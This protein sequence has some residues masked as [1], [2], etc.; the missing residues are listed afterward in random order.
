MNTYASRRLQHAK[1]KWLRQKISDGST[2]Q[3]VRELLRKS[4][5]HTVCQEARCPNMGEC[6]SSGTATFLILGERCTRNCRFCAIAHGPI[7]PPDPEE[8]RRVAEAVRRMG[9]CFTVITSVTR[10]DLPDGGAGHF[11][12]AIHEIRDRVPRTLVE[13][14]VP[15]FGGSDSALETIVK[16]RPDVLNHNIETV[17]GLYS[18][19]R[20]GADYSRSLH[21]LKRVRELSPDMPTKSGL[22]LGLGERPD[23]VEK[24][25]ENLLEVGC[26]ILT[27]GQYLQP[28]KNHLPVKRYVPPEEFDKWKEIALGMGFG[29]VASGPFVRSSYHAGELYGALGEIPP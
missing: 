7:G 1:P 11:A 22:M 4:H 18:Q 17:S 25:F 21:L 16:A 19:V 9:L 20:P 2:Y 10:D 24:V 27:L 12:Q 23:E 29:A 3:K 5:L 13:V 28:S 8:P 26:G 15:D 6:F 14:L